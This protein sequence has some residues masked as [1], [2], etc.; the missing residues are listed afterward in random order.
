[1]SRRISI[2]T[3]QLLGYDKTGGVGTATTF[4]ALGLARVGHTVEI[5]YGGPS[6]A[7]P[8]GEWAAL[9]EEGGVRVRPLPQ[10]ER[11]VEPHPFRRMRRVEVA[12]RD[13]PPDVVITHEYGAP[14][15]TA[16][17]LREL[18]LDFRDT[19]FI[20]LCHGTRRWVKQVNRNPRVSADVLE[21]GVLEE[22]AVALV[23]AVVSPSAF[24][25]D[26]MRS[27]GWPLPD[28]THVIP[29]LT[30][31]AV[32][33][34]HEPHAADVAT[35]VRRVVF[36][37][38]VEER[39]GIEPFLGALNLIPPRFLRG[40]ELAFV[41]SLTKYWPPERVEHEL[42]RAAR[43]ALGR[44]S[45]ASE[46]DQHEAL[47]QLREPG[48]LAVMP[49]LEDNSPN[50]VYECL[51]RRI[52]FIASGA[53]GTYE[54]VA[55]PDRD[56]VLFEPTAESIA[57]ALIRALKSP[58]GVRPAEPAFDG[59][60]SLAAWDVLVQQ[61][62]TAR[63]GNDASPTLDVEIGAEG[64]S[65][66][67]L[68]LGEGDNPE[69]ELLETLVRAQAATGADV[70]TC[71]SANGETEHLY[72]G[73]P[74]GL[75][76]L[77]NGYG[78]AALLPRRL[79]DGGTDSMW[80]LLARLAVSDAK[81]VSVPLPLVYSNDAP[82]DVARDPQS[83]LLVAEE[84]ERALPRPARSLARLAAGLAADAQRRSHAP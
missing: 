33:A 7:A 12:L 81:V 17:E 57:A 16:L 59:A 20:A 65:E 36:F 39:K 74:R 32:T 50:A 75:G 8:A 60:A 25:L 21:E 54:L 27:E 56:R 73:D 76:V 14:A 28:Q 42:T 48:T 19:L 51:E 18:G 64:T 47:A 6:D 30:R 9:Y 43:R 61:A 55:E 15:Y 78:A 82:S 29:Y 38:R 77:S 46:L 5:L 72:V 68:L 2:V 49:S 83:A 71:G 58:D 11:E 84:F 63:G 26:W 22:A 4:L 34:A 37:G 41:G 69:P 45:F 40:I 52:P 23:D 35:R 79:L 13:A 31:S 10:L 67:V 66:W 70:V 62:P 1:M 44:I 53:G 80:P 24:L 3:A